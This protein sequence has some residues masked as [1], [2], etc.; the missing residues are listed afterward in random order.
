M[1]I[2][3]EQHA[4]RQLV[5]A[6]VDLADDVV[7][8]PPRRLLDPLAALRTTPALPLPQ[9]EEVRP[10]LQQENHGSVGPPLEVVPPG[11]IVRVRLALDLDVPMDRNVAGVKQP[12]RPS[13]PAD[14]G[15]SLK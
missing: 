9:R 15:L 8:V 6:A 4:V 3:V 10:R 1:A 2:G 11:W 12:G 13:L 5:A 7:V 14:P